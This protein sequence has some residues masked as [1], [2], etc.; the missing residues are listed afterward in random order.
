VV[1]PSLGRVKWSTYEIDKVGIDGRWGGGLGGITIL[2]QSCSSF[3]PMDPYS[4]VL[5]GA[6]GD[7]DGQ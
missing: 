7:H 2:Q 4:D 3:K 6:E 5:G 1:E